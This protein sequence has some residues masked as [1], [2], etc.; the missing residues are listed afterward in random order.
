M[1]HAGL[2]I[3]PDHAG[4]FRRIGFLGVAAVEENPVAEAVEE[5]EFLELFSAGVATL[6]GTFFS[7]CLVEFESGLA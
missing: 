3:H 5:V 4:I 6:S 2:G 1:I 7:G